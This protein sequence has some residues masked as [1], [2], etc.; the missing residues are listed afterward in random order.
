MQFSQNVCGYQ[1]RLLK[2]VTWA[3]GSSLPCSQ[4]TP[5]W[6]RPWAPPKKSW[7]HLCVAPPF[8]WQGGSAPVVQPHSGLPAPR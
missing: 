6:T 3:V 4:Y 2:K 5:G 8:K 1:P 7:I